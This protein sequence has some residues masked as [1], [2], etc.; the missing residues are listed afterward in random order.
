MAIHKDYAN[1]KRASSKRRAQID[2][3]SGR[4]RSSR[5][6]FN[7]IFVMVFIVGGLFAAAVF[8]LEYIRDFIASSQK[9]EHVE[10]KQTQ[11]KKQEKA[12]ASKK[13]PK[14][15]FYYTLPKME[16]AV[17][18]N[19]SGLTQ[20]QGQSTAQSISKPVTKI[21]GAE[22]KSDNT[23]NTNNAN[24]VMYVLQIASFKELKDANELRARL[25]LIGFDIV[26]Q[27]VQLNTG[28]TWHRVK[29]NKVSTMSKAEQLSAKLQEHN[30]KSIILTEK[31]Y[32]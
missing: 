6:N 15:E 4:N 24:N 22:I 29:T 14:F 21:N 5:R 17:S 18:K 32:G 13:Q 3:K 7:A 27:S 11:T 16:V 25:I 31:N 23:N 19:D 30:I 26:V 28:E 2:A 20:K 1:K 9:T 8:Y 12:V 10:A